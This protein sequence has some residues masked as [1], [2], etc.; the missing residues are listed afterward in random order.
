MK[1]VYLIGLPGCG[2]STVMKEFMSRREG[3]KHDKPI[4]LLDTHLSGNVRVLGKYEEGE[5]FS[6]TD[7]LSMAVAPKAIEWL[8]TNP[9]EF[10]IGEG[11]R[12]NNK[13]FFEMAKTFG[14][15]HIIQLIVSDGERERRYVQRGS[16]Q[17][18]KF[19]QTVMTKCSNIID[20]FG[21]QQTLFG[22]EEGNVVSIQHETESDTQAVVDYIYDTIKI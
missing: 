17:S 20:H 8:S 12:L 6:G 4:D 11:D 2:K 21:D 18:N 19:I 13:A 1:L 7:R 10:V 3:W 15:L 22:F 9:V 16:D 5:T 14:E